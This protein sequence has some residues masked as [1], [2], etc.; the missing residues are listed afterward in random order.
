[1]LAVTSRPSL[2]PLGVEGTSGGASQGKPL[3]AFQA[4]GISE[5]GSSPLLTALCHEL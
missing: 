2:R 4:Q 1:M 5:M 3:G